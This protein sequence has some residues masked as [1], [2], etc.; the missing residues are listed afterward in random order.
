M[1]TVIAVYAI[2]MRVTGISTDPAGVGVLVWAVGALIAVAIFNYRT[3]RAD[4]MLGAAN[5]AAQLVAFTVA[6]AVL[7]ISRPLWTF[8]T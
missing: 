3:H 1:L 6:V 5:A 7:A 2:W 4:P 8:T